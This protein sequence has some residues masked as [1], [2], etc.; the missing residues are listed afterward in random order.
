MWHMCVCISD[1]KPKISIA[2]TFNTQSIFALL[3]I[4]SYNLKV[5]SMNKKGMPQTNYA[6]WKMCGKHIWVTIVSTVKM[7]IMKFPTVQ[8]AMK[9]STYTKTYDVE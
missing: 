9:S 5:L 4:S 7:K 8:I 2:P 3:A 1:S 6:T